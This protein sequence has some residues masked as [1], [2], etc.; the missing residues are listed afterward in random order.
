MIVTD[1]DNSRKGSMTPRD[2]E[3]FSC[4]IRY[5]DDA[6]RINELRQ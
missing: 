3:T 2:I 6:I 5:M 1:T 4:D